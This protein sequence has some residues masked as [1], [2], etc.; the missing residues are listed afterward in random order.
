[1]ILAELAAHGM[2]EFTNLKT[3]WVGKPSHSGPSGGSGTADKRVE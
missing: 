1:M 3:V 2:R